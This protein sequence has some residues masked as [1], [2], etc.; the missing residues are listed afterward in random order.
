MKLTAAFAAIALKLQEATTLLSSDDIARRLSDAIRT[1]YKGTDYWAYMI[2]Y[3]GDD[4]SGDVVFSVSGDLKKAPYTC[5]KAGAAVDT[6]KA[7]DV[8][9]FTTYEVEATAVLEAGKR[10]SSR[11]LAQLQQIHDHSV[12]LGAMCKAK[13]SATGPAG[14]TIKLAEAT[15]F[16][17]DVQLREAFGDKKLFKLIA[18][19]KG[20]TAFYTPECLKQSAADG[21]FKAGTPMRADHPTPAQEAERPEGSVRDWIAVLG[22][23]AYW[24]E[25]AS[26]PAGDGLYSTLK[27]FSESQNFIEERAPY[28][29]VSI[30]AWGEP[31]KENGRIVTREG[32]PVLARLT[33]ADGVDMVT[34]A[35]AG[36]LFLTEAAKPAPNPGGDMDATEVNKLIETALLKQNTA[37]AGQI[38][39]LT[40][41]AIKGEAREAAQTILK[42]STL[43]AVAKARVIE[44]VTA[45]LEA[46]PQKDGVV[47]LVAFTTLVQEAEKREGAYVAGLTGS[48]T[49][50]GMGAAPAPTPIDAKESERRAEAS[51]RLVE[52][53]TQN[54][55]SMGQTPEA[56]KASAERMVFG[57]V[58]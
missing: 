56:A 13:E 5:S 50:K 37:T 52:S 41:R 24:L 15:A 58:A 48:G 31:L 36:G 51:K 25:G 49:V 21:I 18:P 46:I 39:K 6:T 9:P 16:P 26:A 30:A 27:P 3:Y 47:D 23:D 53:A 10:N 38:A 2:T 33:S 14:E 11:D 43:V 12:G 8:V 19:G 45:T 1:A 32:V 28:A 7:V 20:S 42:D 40:E 22:Q 35:G 34:R 17:V 29:G 4:Q 55:I 44:S 57:E 54:F